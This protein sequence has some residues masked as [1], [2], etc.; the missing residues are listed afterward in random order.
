MTK[1]IIVLILSVCA[2]AL[3][4]LTVFI[5]IAADRTGP[6]I[7]FDDSSAEYTDGETN[8]DLLADAKAEDD[9]DGDVSDSLRVI[10]VIKS[11]DG[12]TATVV[13]TAKDSSHNVTRQTRLMHVAGTVQ[14]SEGAAEEVTSGI[15]DTDAASEQAAA[16]AETA[17]AQQ[18]AEQT[19]DA[20]QQAADQAAAQAADPE[21]QAVAE[22]QAAIAALPAG[23]PSVTL[24]THYVTLNTG[25]TFSYMNY[26]GSLSDDTDSS[27]AL[28]QRIEVGGDTVNT[29]QPGTY[30]VVYQVRDTSGNISN[31]AVLH[32]TV[33]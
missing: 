15:N 20:A 8:A 5:Y 17:A 6:V 10:S 24:N 32:V 1:K 7:T 27:S 19:E 28:A 14:P 12:T 33:Q 23:S 13:Y 2:I 25:D 31:Q 30:N 11:T 29:S 9:K 26:I 21:A 22:E 18:G 4:V 16:E 3:A